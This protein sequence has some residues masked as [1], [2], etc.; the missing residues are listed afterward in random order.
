M[1]GNIPAML[2][3]SAISFNVDTYE[4]TGSVTDALTF[5][6]GTAITQRVGSVSAWVKYKTGTDTSG[7][8]GLDTATFTVLVY[9]NVAGIDSVVGSD[10]VKIFPGASWQN[11][12]ANVKYTDS[13]NGADTV[14][15]LFMSSSNAA[16]DSSTLNVDDVSM[17]Y[18]P[19]TGIKYIGSTADVRVYPNPAWEYVFVEGNTTATFNLFDVK[20]AMVLTK[21][22]DGKTAVDISAL[23][24]GF[25]FYM[26]SDQ[27]G[28][29]LQRGKL[30]ICR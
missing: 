1:L 18:L 20:G 15:L 3:N 8:T 7:I 5:S 23:A 29:T 14:R 13:V 9:S 22:I 30:T 6:G 21:A 24:G 12:T 2:S 27:N 17:T 26:A 19:N 10:T 28:N 16:L 4:L 11:V 25:Y